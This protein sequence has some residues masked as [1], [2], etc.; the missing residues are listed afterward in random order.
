MELKRVLLG[1]KVAHMR[2]GGRRIFK[3]RPVERQGSC[4]LQVSTF[5]V[6][7]STGHPHPEILWVLDIPACA[8]PAR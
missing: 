7:L 8:F 5:N 4:H 1:G 2:G 6:L 3:G